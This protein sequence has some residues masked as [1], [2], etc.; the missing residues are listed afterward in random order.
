MTISTLKEGKI[1]LPDL[2][3]NKDTNSS[4][5]S[6]MHTKKNNSSRTTKALGRQALKSGLG[7]GIIRTGGRVGARM[8][9]QGVKV[10]ANLLRSGSR[11]YSLSILR[12][13][14]RAL[15]GQVITAFITLVL[16]TL[17]DLFF[18]I[19]KERSIKQFLVNI[20]SNV[21]VIF[22]GTLFFGLS[23]Q[24]VIGLLGK[25]HK[26][27][28]IL[29]FALAFAVSVAVCVA[30][31]FI[32]DKAVSG[33][34]KSD[35]DNMLEIIASEYEDMRT[36]AGLGTDD[37]GKILKTLE[38]S[39]TPGLIR[40]MFRSDDR[41]EFAKDLLNKAVESSGIDIQGYNQ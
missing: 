36:A 26:F 15:M 35:T 5:L 4:D 11:V 39:I 32:F 34:F 3:R 2:R 25:D 37:T 13:A 40:K 28:G 21:W 30:A 10:V 20:L 1:T 8:S 16:F 29:S 19:R 27:A 31:G 41:Q 6:Y 12:G 14:M 18:L 7:K 38:E 22:W 24:A 33:V 9:E 17:F 23:E